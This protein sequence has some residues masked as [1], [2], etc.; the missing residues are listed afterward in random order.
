MNVLAPIVSLLLA[1]SPLTAA[2]A[3]GSFGGA[4]AA[5]QSSKTGPKVFDNTNWAGYVATAHGSTSFQ[6]AL[7]TFKIPFF[8]CSVEPNSQASQWVGLGGVNG[9]VNLLQSGIEMKCSDGLPKLYA[10][11]QDGATTPEVRIQQPVAPGDQMQFQVSEAYQLF[12]A[13]VVVNNVTQAWRFATNVATTG[14]ISQTGECIAERDTVGDKQPP[15][16]Q[17]SDMQF[18]GRN[19]VTPTSGCV[20]SGVTPT[21]GG[22]IDPACTCLAQDMSA[23][24]TSVT[25]K[26]EFLVGLKHKKPPTLASPSAPSTDGG[27]SITWN[28]AQ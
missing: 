2:Q 24:G 13:G 10:W 20:M 8:S 17:F 12:Q 15:L 6:I 18:A 4:G 21:T 25:V 27:F 14:P 11:Y 26:I 23:T 3:H 9:N 19:S 28:K 5:P 16:T 1:L 7:A 22:P